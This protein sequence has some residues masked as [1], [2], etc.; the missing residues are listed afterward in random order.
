M[1]HETIFTVA[2]VLLFLFSNAT[3]QPTMA[4]SVSPIDRQQTAMKPSARGGHC[5]VYD[6]QLRKVMLLD[7]Y[8]LPA[9]P[10]L[11]EV[12]AWDGKRWE[13]IPGSGPA[14][15]FLG[16]A[17]YDSRR[18]K[19]VLYGGVG[20]SSSPDQPQP[21]YN[22]TWEWDGKSW[23]QMTDISA[24]TRN[25]HAM[26]YG[27]ARG[28][29]VLFGGASSHTL[30]P[31]SWE[32]A[33]DTWEWDGMKWTPIATPGPSGR[34][35][36]AMANDS[37][38][39]KVILFGGR[40][41]DEKRYNDTWAWDGKTWEKISNEGPPRSNHRMAFD[42]RAGVILLYGG[43]EGM[44]ETSSGRRF[45]VRED[46]WQWDGKQSSPRALRPTGSL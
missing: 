35:H 17:V 28:R 20:G 22:D 13:L 5:F 4:T 45:I 19:I 42:R 9:Q 27:E 32:W 29:N 7:G 30:P 18:K 36:F 40:D 46:M 43:D 3:T 34:V 44:T 15:R 26:A 12:W 16:G 24:G 11:G 1:I 6:E 41:K 39:K 8:P 37:K 38:R 14:A 23:R 33:S 10:K 25:H 31:E 21:M 2:T